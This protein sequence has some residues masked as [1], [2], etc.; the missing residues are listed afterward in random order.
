[1]YS[2]WHLADVKSAQISIIII[3]HKP[4][5]IAVFGK[6]DSTIYIFC[7]V[8]GLLSS[9]QM[10][11]S[12]S[13]KPKPDTLF[14]TKKAWHTVPFWTVAALFCCC[15]TRLLTQLG[16]AADLSGPQCAPGGLLEPPSLQKNDFAKNVP[17]PDSRACNISRALAMRPPVGPRNPP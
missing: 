14:N 3:K 12:V 9:C 16:S 1:M 8:Q 5:K 10:Q 15:K 6:T 13:P 11:R 17:G 2:E 4:K 7:G